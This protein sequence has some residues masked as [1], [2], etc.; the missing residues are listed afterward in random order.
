MS[1]TYSFNKSSPPSEPQSLTYYDTDA[2]V[3]N[4]FF[5][6]RDGAELFL[7]YAY[8]IAGEISPEKNAI[9]L[10]FTT[11]TVTLQGRKLADLFSRLSG[12]GAQRIEAL[13]ERYAATETAENIVTQ[14][15]VQRHS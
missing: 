2:R 12:H 5:V 13:E 6:P 14:I 10:T 9:T 4:V 1:L 11:H 15:K 7:N 3:R 8:L